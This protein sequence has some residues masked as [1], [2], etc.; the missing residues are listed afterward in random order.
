MSDCT[1][2]RE[3]GRPPA[4]INRL[5]SLKGLGVRG[6][7]WL[8]VQRAGGRGEEEK[9]SPLPRGRESPFCAQSRSAR[10]TDFAQVVVRT[11]RKKSSENGKGG[12]RRTGFA[13]AK[14]VRLPGTSWENGHVGPSTGYGRV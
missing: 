11:G 10:G 9:S 6:M 3:T 14:P 12:P 7:D 1:A 8:L 13:R 5:T 4:S 2:E